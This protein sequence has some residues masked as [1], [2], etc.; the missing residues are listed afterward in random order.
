MLTIFTGAPGTDRCVI[1]YNPKTTSCI[2][3]GAITHTGA[4]GNGFRQCTANSS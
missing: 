4:T 2:L 3:V 1:G